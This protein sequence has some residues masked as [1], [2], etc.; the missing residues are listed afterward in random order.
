ME[1]AVSLLRLYDTTVSAIARRLGVNWHSCWNTVKKHA[2]TSID[3]KKRASGGNA[4]GVDEHIWRPS[5]ISSADKAVTVMVDLTR[6]P[7]RPLCAEVTVSVECAEL[8]PFHGYRNVIRDELPD[9]VAVLDAFH[10]VKLAGNALDEVRSPVQVATLGRRGHKDDPLY[11]I[12]RTL[13]LSDPNSEVE[14]TW[15]VY[16]RVRSIYTVTSPAAS[17]KPAEK[18]PRVA[19]HPPDPRGRQL[20]RTLRQWHTE[21]RGG[22]RVRP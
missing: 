6:G 14:V 3:I 7:D 15:H 2:E 13:P 19:P 8:D 16:Q 22:H 17:R 11:R 21:M 9:A 18:G 10:V 4:I 12:R 20:G 5:S 1:W